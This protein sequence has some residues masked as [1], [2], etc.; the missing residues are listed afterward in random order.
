[1]PPAKAIAAAQSQGAGKVYLIDKPGAPQSLIYA[2]HVAATGARPDDLALETVMRNF[3]GMATSRLNRNLRLD[4]HWSYGT[5]GGIS[6]A[7]GPR[8]FNVI[9]PVQTDKTPEAMI[10]V[11][12]EIEGVAGARPLA[13]EELESILR[14]QV[15]RLPGRFETLD[16][17]LV[18]GIDLVNLDR[19]PRY[20]TEYAPTLRQLGGDALNAAAAA[21]VKPPQ[22]TWIVVGD[23]KQIEAGVRQLGFG[24]VETIAV[25]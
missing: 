18:A 25:P 10:E 13:G 2:A 7:R 15:S 8:L 24:E 9:A 1:M 14:S 6:G 12:R 21:V 11:K 3:G 5:M 4:K 19:D 22:L 20:Y 17:L 16:S 23:L